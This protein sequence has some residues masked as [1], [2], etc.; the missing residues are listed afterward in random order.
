MLTPAACDENLDKAIAV[1]ELNLLLITSRIWHLPRC[2]REG[3]IWGLV[4]RSVL[5]SDPCRRRRVESWRGGKAEMLRT[6]TQPWSVHGKAGLAV[7][8]PLPEK[9]L[10][11]LERCL[12]REMQMW[13]TYSINKQFK[14]TNMFIVRF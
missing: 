4:M 5:S 14:F 11:D 2:E 3:I 8:V 1:R 6:E 7:E 12:E 10:S 9:Y 13:R